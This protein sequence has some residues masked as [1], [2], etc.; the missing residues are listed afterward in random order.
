METV[1]E[2]VV[3]GKVTRRLIPFLFVLYIFNFLDRTNVNVA[4]L[5]MK[6]DLGFSDTVY[7]FGAGVFFLGYFF[8]EVP[9]NLILER[10]GARIW[11]ARIMV[12]WGIISSATLFVHSMAGFFTMRFLLGVAEAGFFPGMILYLSYWF[13]A[14]ERARAVSRF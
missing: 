11:M 13:P 2:K 8:F 4:A 1:A 5:R 9:S 10:I 7:G 12:T 14:A 6:P 3:L